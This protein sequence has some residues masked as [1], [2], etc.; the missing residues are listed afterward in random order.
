MCKKKVSE[1]QRWQ[2]ISLLKDKTKTQQEIADLVE[3][4]SKCV[5]TT[6]RN[7]EKTFVIKELPRSGRPRKSYIFRKV[8]INPTTSYRQLSS[9]FIKTLLKWCKERQ[10]WTV[11]DWSKDVFSDESN[12]EILNRKSRVFVKRFANEKY[13]PKFYLPKLQNRGGSVGTGCCSIYTGRI[14]QFVN[15]PCIKKN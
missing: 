7:Y 14:N 6:K 8:R 12:F 2:I 15:I 13:H 11:N 5:I 9:D 4:S 3:V 1:A 10:R